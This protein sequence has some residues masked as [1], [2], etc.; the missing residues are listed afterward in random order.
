MKMRKFIIVGQ[1]G[2]GKSSFINATFG[3]N[4]A[5][6]SEFEA[7]TK[8][9]T[10]YAYGTSYGDVCLVDTPGLSESTVSLD[11]AYLRMMRDKTNINDFFATIYVTPLNETRF[12]SSEKSAL[13]SL[14]DELGAAI[15]SKAWLV[16]TFA[17][18]VPPTRREIVWKTRWKHITN[19]LQEL[20]VD[21]KPFIGFQ[22][23]LLI[24]NVVPN[25]TSKGVPIA[26]VL[27]Q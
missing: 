26:S 7:C 20:T 11:V 3:V 27:T 10:H 22:K 6:V 23:I 24:D 21:T 5:K 19:Y 17:A 2:V 9:V 13:K 4:L 12:R 8:V 14:T 1:T 25:W 16:F 15:W 18:S